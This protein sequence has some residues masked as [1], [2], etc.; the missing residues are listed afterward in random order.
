MKIQNLQSEKDMD[1]LGQY[2]SSQLSSATPP[3]P[4]DIAERLRIARQTALAQR[5]PLLRSRLSA[6]AQLQS[7]GS[8]SAPS[9]EGLTVWSFLASVLPLLVLLA[10]LM[11]IQWI[12]QDHIAA[13]I[14][15]TDAALLTD[16]LPPDAYTDP[17]FAQFLSK[18][19]N[20][21]AAND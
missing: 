11:A 15:A 19:L 10:G 4:H 14:A 2:F 18:G 9:D 21:R 13:E 12:Q 6:T 17:G 8:L 1:R 20:T 5:K 7:N 3:L 16:D